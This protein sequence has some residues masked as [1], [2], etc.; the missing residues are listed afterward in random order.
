MHT[1][2]AF[3]VYPM[4]RAQ[5]TRA[6]RPA[7]L[8]LVLVPLIF[9]LLRMWSAIIDTFTIYIRGNSKHPFGDEG[10]YSLVFIAVSCMTS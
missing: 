1:L 4:Q 10:T 9:L 2:D 3:F 5:G 6:R 8:K 7:D